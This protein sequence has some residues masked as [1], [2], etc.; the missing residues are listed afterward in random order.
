MALHEQFASRL[1]AAKDDVAWE[2]LQ[3][4]VGRARLV[5]GQVRM[6]TK[7]MAALWESEHQDA[8]QASELVFGQHF[9]V[10]QTGPDRFWG[11]C[12]EDGYVGYVDRS[13]VSKP[14]S[15]THEVIARSA[16]VRYEADIKAPP[17]FT[18]PLGARITVTGP[19][20]NNFVT[21]MVGFLPVHALRELGMD[22]DA[23]LLTKTLEGML[24]TPYVW[25][26]GSY[27]GIDCSGLVQAWV[28]LVEPGV[29]RDADMQEASLGQQ[30]DDGSRQVGDF[31]FW[32]G[33]VAIIWRHQTLFHASGHHMAVVMEPLDKALARIETTSG[34]VRT[35]RRHPIMAALMRDLV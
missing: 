24:G 9:R 20:V 35:A 14:Q 11:Q 12:L 15:L 29:L 34:P 10:L 6:V 13:D 25:G 8:R 32:P 19:V 2:G 17:R 22:V 5:P 28:R 16:P 27:T 31:L 30:I 26:G 4:D 18:L 33:H 3:G 1:R 23:A 7:P 21:T